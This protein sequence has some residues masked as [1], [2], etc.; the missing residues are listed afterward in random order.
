MISPKLIKPLVVCFDFK[1]S[2][3]I[4]YLRLLAFQHHGIYFRYFF[5]VSEIIIQEKGSKLL[6]DVT[7]NNTKGRYIFLLCLWYLINVHVQWIISKHLAVNSFQTIC[8]I[9]AFVIWISKRLYIVW[10]VKQFIL[11]LRF[12]ENITNTY[13]NLHFMRREK[14]NIYNHLVQSIY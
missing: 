7:D 14:I 1:N 5:F 10:T 13:T 6:K 2:K 3:Q 12:I 4:T 8:G 11:S 9:N